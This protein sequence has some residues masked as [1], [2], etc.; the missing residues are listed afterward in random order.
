MLMLAVYWNEYLTFFS[1]LIGLILVMTIVYL[2]FFRPVDHIK[3]EVTTPTVDKDHDQ[4]DD[5]Q[6]D[7]FQ[8]FHVTEEVEENNNFTMDDI[9][10]HEEYIRGLYSNILDSFESEMSIHQKNEDAKDH[11]RVEHKVIKDLSKVVNKNPVETSEEQASKVDLTG[12]EEDDLALLKRIIGDKKR[13]KDNGEFQGKYH[14]LYNKDEDRWYVK[15]EGEETISKL[16]H[17]Q[18]EGIAYATIKAIENDTNIV[19]HDEDGKIIKYD[20]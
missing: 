12:V 14:V 17:S 8:E 6:E 7:S 4:A 11:A 3:E 20:F 18:T 1:A 13:D 10:E 5:W 15:R 9:N 16:L 2:I 19:V